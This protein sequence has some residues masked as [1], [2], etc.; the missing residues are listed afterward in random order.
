MLGCQGGVYLGLAVCH[1]L[2]AGKKMTCREIAA[3][4][5]CQHSYIAQLEHSALAKVRKAMAEQRS[6][7][8]AELES[9]QEMQDFRALV[10]RAKRRGWVR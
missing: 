10:A 9:K 7:Q 3:W 8:P 6:K 5:G 2:N 1:V 4:C